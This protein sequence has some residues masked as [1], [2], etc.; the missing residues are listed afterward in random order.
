MPATGSPQLGYLAIV[1]PQAFAGHPSE[2]ILPAFLSSRF[3]PARLSLPAF[4]FYHRSSR[5]KVGPY[6]DRSPQSKHQ[7]VYRFVIVRGGRPRLH[8][9]RFPSLV[10]TP[11]SR[12]E[13]P[14]FLISRF[15]P[16]RFPTSGFLHLSPEQS[17][18]FPI[19]G[20]LPARRSHAAVRSVKSV[21]TP[22]TRAVAKSAS[23]SA[24]AE[25]QFRG[26]SSTRIV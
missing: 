24:S 9:K 20:R 5:R 6:R 18:R 13:N 25:G 4:P 15:S 21:K 14:A 23:C 7:A 12:A 17:G 3:T 10:R 1:S 16:T 8:R 19:Q 22:S 26:R 2:R 11:R